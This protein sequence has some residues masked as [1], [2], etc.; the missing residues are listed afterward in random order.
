MKQCMHMSFRKSKHKGI[1]GSFINVIAEERVK[2]WITSSLR[3]YSGFSSERTNLSPFTRSLRLIG[4]HSL[5]L[6]ST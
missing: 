3:L 4:N 5:F 6:S 2:F 1:K